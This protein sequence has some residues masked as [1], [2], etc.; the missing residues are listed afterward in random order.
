VKEFDTLV[1][2]ITREYHNEYP[3]LARNHDVILDELHKEIEKFLKVLDQGL[4]LFEKVSKSGTVSADDAFTLFTAQGFPLEMIEE[5]AHE[6]GITVDVSGFHVL[7]KEHQEKSRTAAAGKFKG[8]LADHSEMTTKYHTAN[9]MMLEAMKRVLGHDAV[10]QK[11]SNIT[12]ERLRFDFSFP[13]K[14]T[15]EEIQQ[16]EDIVN[17]EIAKEHRV[18]YEEMSV[19][20]AKALGATGVFEH[21]YGDRVKVYFIGDFSKEICGG[22]HVTTTKGMGTL[23]I[24]KE[25]ASSA[26]VR[27]IKAILM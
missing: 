25:E 17:A 12:S 13:R 27:R 7:M 14:L 11:G 22:P 20:E 3:E 18:H 4:K 10:H 16:I 5:L 21:K 9:H 26:G 1:Q 19:D 23:K 8:G 6:K 15:S 24:Q 2:I